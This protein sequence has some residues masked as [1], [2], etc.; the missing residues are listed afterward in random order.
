MQRYLFQK[1]KKSTQYEGKSI[2]LFFADATAID[3]RIEIV[4]IESMR[5]Y[6]FG[7]FLTLLLSLAVTSSASAQALSQRWM[8]LDAHY[9]SDSSAGCAG[10]GNRWHRAKLTSKEGAEALPNADTYVVECFTVNNEVLCTTGSEAADTKVFGANNM[11]KLNSAINYRF[12]GMFKADGQTV[13]PN[14][15]K[16]DATGKIAPVEWQSFSKY[17]ARKFLAVNFFSGENAQPGSAGG[18]QQGTLEFEVA[19]SD[20]VAINWDPFGRV[21]DAQTLE[22]I[23][24]AVVTLMMKNGSSYKAATNADFGGFSAITNPQTTKGDGL[25]EFVVPDNTYKLQVSAPGYTFPL[26]SLSSLNSGYSRIYKDIYPAQTG[27]DI[28]QKGKIQHRDIPLVATGANQDNPVELIEYFTTLDK[29]TGEYVIEGRV[30]HPFAK[31]NVWT[32][33]EGY[34]TAANPHFRVAATAKA[35]VDGKFQVRVDQS[36]FEQGEVVSNLEVVKQPLTTGSMSWIDRLMGL[37]VKDANAQDSRANAAIQPIPNYL[38]GVAYDRNNNPIPNA[39]VSVYVQGSQVPYH[40]VVADETGKFVISSEYWP[41]MPYSLEYTSANGT[42]T[43][44]STSTYME[45]NAEYHK[46]NNVD[47]NILKLKN[48]TVVRETPGEDVGMKKGDANTNM[49]KSSPQYA[50][51]VTIMLIIMLIVIAVILVLFVKNKNKGKTMV[52]PSGDNMS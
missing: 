40:S 32:D 25:F 3:I 41:F 49:M 27:E 35:D 28:V 42:T 37:F 52:P 20:C 7:V 22:P 2:V 6:L 4:H 44:V 24:G 29:V 9:C 10:V 18:Q 39:Q 11:P 1:N 45:Q 14:P 43:E 13:A 38:E 26:T 17:T 50:F 12:E 30:S 46:A 23:K 51:I 21:F 16:A 8:C 36:A 19:K 47:S 31:V 5:R 34:G 48:G 15:T 33:K